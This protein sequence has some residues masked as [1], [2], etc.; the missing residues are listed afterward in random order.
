[1]RAAVLIAVLCLLSVVAVKAYPYDEDMYYDEDF[2]VNGAGLGLGG[3]GYG[4][5]APLAYAAAPVAYAAPAYGFAMPLN[6]KNVQPV[7][8]TKVRYAQPIVTYAQP[9][10]Q[11]ADMSAPLIPTTQKTA[12]PI[13]Q[14]TFQVAPVQ[15]AVSLAA[16]APTIQKGYG[17]GLGLG[18]AHGF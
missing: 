10:V 14:P 17:T 18:L 15:Q 5:A 7:V 2:Q 3:F 4:L 16:T 12:Q 6:T 9:I 13:Y 1:M 11:Q 8:N